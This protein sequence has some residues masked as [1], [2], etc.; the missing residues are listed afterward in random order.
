METHSSVLAWRIPGTGEPGG[1]PSMGSHRVGHDWSNLAAVAAAVAGL[2]TSPCSCLTTSYV[3][4]SSISPFIS[5]FHLEVGESSFCPG[6]HDLDPPSRLQSELVIS[7]WCLTWGIC[8][9]KCVLKGAWALSF[10]LGSTHP[11]A[12]FT[13]MWSP[14]LICRAFPYYLSII[15][16]PK[17]HLLV[18][19]C[20]CV[21]INAHTENIVFLQ[22]LNY[23][24]HISW[25]K[26]RL[27][28]GIGFRAG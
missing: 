3:L 9:Q 19:I 18:Y 4:G 24:I 2:S 26:G 14:F 15:I 11:T 17:P 21:Y 10:T 13:L 8:Y 7:L 27:L 5:H 28:Y 16:W 12:L 23:A 6:L 1:L 22:M 25:A 20:V